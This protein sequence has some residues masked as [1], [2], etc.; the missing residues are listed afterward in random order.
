MRYPD[1]EDRL[2]GQEKLAPFCV[3]W[4]ASA[5]AIFIG[6]WVSI[7]LAWMSPVTMT[8]TVH[9]NATP[10]ASVPSS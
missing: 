9:V 6:C 1:L 2:A 3:R 4:T 7:S 10:A 5:A 8:S